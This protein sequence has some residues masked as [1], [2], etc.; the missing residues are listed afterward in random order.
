ML[1]EN[2]KR[3]NADVPLEE[4]KKLKIKLFGLDITFADWLRDAIE[5]FLKN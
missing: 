2:Y 1:K 3:L 4:Y 5:Q